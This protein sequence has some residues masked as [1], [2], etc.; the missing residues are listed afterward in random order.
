LAKYGIQDT[1]PGSTPLHRDQDCLFL[2]MEKPRMSSVG[3]GFRATIGVVLA[4]VFVFV[5]LPIMLCGGGF[6]SI[7]APAV[8]EAAK[9]AAEASKRAD[10]KPRQEEQAVRQRSEQKSENKTNNTREPAPAKPERTMPDPEPM[11]EASPGKN[12]GTP[13]P[14]NTPAK[15]TPT[16]PAVEP[17]AEPKTDTAAADRALKLAKGLLDKN[18]ATA[19]KRLQEVVD[20]YPGTDV[21]AEAKAI[22]EK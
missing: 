8:N 14:S 17:K 20:K 10:E 18:P 2:T 19:K 9:Q 4:L 21:A 7:V 16:E 3:A 6:S 22:L 11:P 1:D 15:P 12:P 13:E 5:V